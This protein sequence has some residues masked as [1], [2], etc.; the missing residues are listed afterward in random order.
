MCVSHST[1]EAEVVAA[2]HAM[3]SYGLPCLDVWERLLGRDVRLHFHEDNETAIIAMRRGYSPALRHIRR[4]HGVCLRWLAERFAQDAHDL[5]YERS[6]L[7]AA[8]IYTK[9]FTVPAEW[10]RACRLI[11]VLHPSRFWQPDVSSRKVHEG[12]MGDTHKG[13][14]KFSYWTSNP[15]L[16]RTSKSIPKPADGSGALTAAATYECSVE[17]SCLAAMFGFRESCRSVPH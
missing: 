2:D 4:T 17:S 7:Q 11:N 10:D 13:D 9:A 15:W 3:R 12:E 5:F 1:P 16:N 14:V 6:A 8:D